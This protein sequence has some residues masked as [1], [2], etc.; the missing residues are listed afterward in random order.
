MRRTRPASKSIA[1]SE[2][3]ASKRK[4]PILVDKKKRP[5]DTIPEGLGSTTTPGYMQSLV[6]RIGSRADIRSSA[7]P[8]SRKSPR[9]RLYDSLPLFGRK[10]KLKARISEPEILPK[11]RTS[12][13]SKLSTEIVPD[14]PSTPSLKFDS[15]RYSSFSEDVNN[16]SSEPRQDKFEL[17]PPHLSPM[18]YAR[19][20][21]IE[22]AH[23]AKENRSCDLPKP[24]H[25][26]YWT[27]RWEK[28]IIIPKIPTS[29]KR[30]EPTK[31]K[32]KGCSLFSKSS[33]EKQA[34]NDSVC[35][36]LSLHLDNLT[37]LFPSMTNLDALEEWDE[38]GVRE[39][40]AGEP[41]MM[42]GA[43]L[44]PESLENIV[45]GESVQF[46]E[47]LK[48]HVYTA[49][50][51]KSLS[52]GTDVTNF[53]ECLQEAIRA[54]SGEN[55]AAE[56]SSGNVRP[57]TP[58]GQDFVLDSI[59][60]EGSD[61]SSKYSQGSDDT[62]TAFKK[63]ADHTNQNWLTPKKDFDDKDFASPASASKD[64]P[65]DATKYD[66]SSPMAHWPFASGSKT[67]RTEMIQGVIDGAGGIHARTMHQ[68]QISETTSVQ[69]MMAE[70]QPAPLRIP[71]NGWSGARSSSP[72]E[73]QN[74]EGNG[75]ED[76]VSSAQEEAEEDSPDFGYQTPS[77]RRTTTR[78]QSSPAEL[79]MSPF[80]F[81]SD[82]SMNQS[83]G[84]DSPTLPEYHPYAEQPLSSP[85]FHQQTLD[86]LERGADAEPSFAQGD[87]TIW[88]DYQVYNEQPERQ[89]HRQA[90]LDN[91]ESQTPTQAPYEWVP[92][93][94]ERDANRTPS[95]LPLLHYE[96]SPVR[97]HFRHNEQRVDPR[98]T[99][100]TSQQT[101]GRKR[102]KA[103]SLNSWLGVESPQ[104]IGDQTILPH[105]EGQSSGDGEAHEEARTFIVADQHGES[106]AVG[107]GAGETTDYCQCEDVEP[108]RFGERSTARRLV[109]QTTVNR[110]EESPVDSRIIESSTHDRLREPLAGERFGE[111][112]SRLG[113]WEETTS[114]PR[115]T[116]IVVDPH[117]SLRSNM[118]THERLALS[119][120]NRL[121]PPPVPSAAHSAWS[122]SPSPNSDR[123]RGS[124]RFGSLFRRKNRDKS[125]KTSNSP[126]TNW[127][128]Y[129]DSSPGPPCSKPWGAQQAEGPREDRE[130]RVNFF[131]RRVEQASASDRNRTFSG[132]Q[133]AEIQRDSLVNIQGMIEQCP[134]PPPAHFT[135]DEPSVSRL[136]TTHHTGSSLVD[137]AAHLGETGMA[138]YREKKPK[139]LSVD[140]NKLRKK[141]SED[142]MKKAKSSAGLRSAFWKTG[143][144]RSKDKDKDNKD[145][146][147]DKNKEV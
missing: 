61:R 91:L 146:G 30:G 114:H 6:R 107:V 18:E 121:P 143:T 20:Y 108:A 140:T 23:A 94:N 145:K 125:G 28:F 67:T 73:P 12:G 89:S 128:P 88:P 41:P 133:R 62:V 120:Q 27:P 137:G 59:D 141:K 71:S 127:Q 21:L 66:G 14:S 81:P 63:M 72:N 110:F 49:G 57:A 53:T 139:E 87:S 44:D 113:Q 15:T 75:N 142:A 13:P 39:V 105:Y 136:P 42:S 34:T 22:K 48:G 98:D 76:E 115:H 106:S 68:P 85:Q 56:E 83:P 58:E 77:L 111:P 3:K 24:E 47:A 7:S 97:E 40:E 9:N 122:H 43:L 5:L 45:E 17:A 104:E 117:S 1:L 79:E 130:E 80:R 29:I 103:E 95:P 96:P 74:E 11:R 93:E 16:R 26:W 112:A 46:P 69:S 38:Y 10:P 65:D 134:V 135:F 64:S 138:T 78:L 82:E 116:P 109:H 132:A 99:Q 92:L 35:P 123:G 55:P 126:S 100:Y 19:T 147:K 70:L 36:R 33:A 124:S 51:R 37:S 8:E 25:K 118:T 84:G 4:T 31:V 52:T 102:S 2:K 50:H 129:E 131:R 86:L 32:G 60:Q 54:Y 90:T 101:G 119:H 144:W